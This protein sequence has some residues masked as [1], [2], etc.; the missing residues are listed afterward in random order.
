MIG[1]F[2]IYG[3]PDA[4]SEKIEG[5]MKSGVTLV[6]AGSPIRPGMNAGSSAST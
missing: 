4:L 6:V 2:S 3:T 1:A 5:L